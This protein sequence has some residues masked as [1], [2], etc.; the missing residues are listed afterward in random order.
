MSFLPR[1]DGADYGFTCGVERAL[2]WAS[3]EAKHALTP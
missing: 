3:N 2:E 1:Y